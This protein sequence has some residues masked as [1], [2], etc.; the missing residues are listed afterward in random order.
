M[1]DEI[2]CLMMNRQMCRPDI[3][4]GKYKIA[5][6]ITKK[7]PSFEIC[8][9]NHNFYIAFIL[10]HIQFCCKYIG[11]GRPAIISYIILRRSSK[12]YYELEGWLVGWVLPNYCVNIYWLFCCYC[13]YCLRACIIPWNT[14]VCF[15]WQSS[16]LL[17]VGQQWPTGEQHF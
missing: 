9:L 4:S 13:C 5:P 17:S 3:Q 12:P 6:N 15:E 16:S 7:S 1:L 2:W 11:P 14:I 10:F 8:I